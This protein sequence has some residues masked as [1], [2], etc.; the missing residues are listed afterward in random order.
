MNKTE[1]TLP[2]R[3]L[4][5][6]RNALK[7]L[8][9][10]VSKAIEGDPNADSAFILSAKQG[11]VSSYSVEDLMNTKISEPSMGSAIPFN[12]LFFVDKNVYWC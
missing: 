3:S 8:C 12:F 7:R 2:P 10:I 6:G 11:S 4:T 5:L 1:I 9:E